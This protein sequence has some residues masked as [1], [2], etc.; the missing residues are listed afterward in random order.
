LIFGAVL[1]R[2]PTPPV[3]INPDVPEDVERVIKTALEKDR[4]LRY[5]A[6]VPVEPVEAFLDS[7]VSRRERSW[8]N[9]C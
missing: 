2:A 5:R 8:L 7:A 6:D 3:R 9:Y 1:K 4:A